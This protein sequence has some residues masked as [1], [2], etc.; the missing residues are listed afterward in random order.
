MSSSAART[1][2]SRRLV[3]SLSSL[4]FKSSRACIVGSAS[5]RPRKLRYEKS[6][7]L[8]RVLLA[9]QLAF[10]LEQFRRVHFLSR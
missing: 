7:L 1:I 4:T 6:R 10:H 2:A 5:K 3:I 8:L 9:D